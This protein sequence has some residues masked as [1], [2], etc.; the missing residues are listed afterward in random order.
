[1]VVKM[2]VKPIAKL[3]KRRGGTAAA[4]LKC[5]GARIAVSYT[6]PRSPQNPSW[7]VQWPAPKQADPSHSSRQC[8]S[9]NLPVISRL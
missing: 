6:R 8:R 3:S 5:D 1:M 9:S 4:Y 2:V 7:S